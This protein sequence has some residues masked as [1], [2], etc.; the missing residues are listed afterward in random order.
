MES[1]SAPKTGKPKISAVLLARNEEANIRY[2]LETVRWCSE[3]IVVDMESSDRTREIAK[4]YTDRVYSHPRLEVFDVAK[5]FAVEKADGDWILLVDADE[6]V[7]H[8]LSL[9]LTG[10]ALKNEADIVEV[11]FNNYIMG[12]RV[13]HSGWGATAPPRFFRKGKI[14]FTET[15]HD[16]MQRAPGARV[17][18]LEPA[19]ANCISHFN[20]S[21]SAQFVEKLNRYTDVE[22]QHLFDKGVIFSYLGLFRA[23]LSEFYWRFIRHSGYKNGVR[24]FSLCLMMAFYRALAYIKLWEKY[25]FREL[26]V[27][28]RYKKLRESILAGWG[29]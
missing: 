22:A 14:I 27:S 26:L 17:V 8:S 23:A 10:L 29:K 9:A 6:M 20:Y 19:E 1:N 25:E 24:G 7:P 2:C 12:D 11:P 4:E 18:R 28:E 15:I 13:G 16:Y 5:K 21:D 3:I